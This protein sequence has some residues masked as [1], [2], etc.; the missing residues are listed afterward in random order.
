MFTY[1]CTGAD[2]PISTEMEILLE[3]LLLGAPAPKLTPPPQTGITGK[4]TSL[5]R[6]LLGMP[7]SALRSVLNNSSK[8]AIIQ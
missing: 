7:V 1:N 5:Q 2:R 3:R 6:L 4:E 8:S